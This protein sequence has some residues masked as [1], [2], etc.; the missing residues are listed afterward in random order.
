M[1][2]WVTQSGGVVAT[3]GDGLASVVTTTS[4]N[5][6]RVLGCLWRMVY[7]KDSEGA[8]ST[9]RKQG[10]RVDGE[11]KKRGSQL[12]LSHMTCCAIDDPFTYSY[13]YLHVVHT[14]VDVFGLLD[15]AALTF[16]CYICG[17]GSLFLPFMRRNPDKGVTFPPG[18]SPSGMVYSQ[19]YHC[20]YSTVNLTSSQ[21]SNQDPIVQIYRVLQCREFTTLI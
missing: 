10:R 1:A 8:D 7:K 18:S 16:T 9:A 17:F 4:H 20:R 11:R 12:G 6:V 15:Q 13:C 2:V 21:S 5:R 3:L 14:T 19:F